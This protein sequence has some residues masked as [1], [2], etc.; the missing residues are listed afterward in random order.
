MTTERVS[1]RGYLKYAGAVVVV[2]VVAAAGYGIYEVTK[3]PPKPSIAIYAYLTTNVVV[4]WDPS[5]TYSNEV[6]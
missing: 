3:P 2:G 6:V 5:E 1:R 4:F